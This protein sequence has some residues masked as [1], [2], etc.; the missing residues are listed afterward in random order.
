MNK[1]TLSLQ[2][3][4]DAG[5]RRTLFEE[6]S[7]TLSG[8]IAR[9]ACDDGPGSIARLMER[10]FQTGLAMRGATDLKEPKDDAWRPLRETDLPSSLRKQLYKFR[11]LLG[12][13]LDGLRLRDPT[14]RGMLLVMPPRRPGYP[15]ENRRDEWFSPIL[16]WSVPYSLNA[17]NQMVGFGLF[18]RPQ[19]LRGG[20][21]MTTMTEWGFEFLTIGETRHLNDR[22]PGS[23]LT[24]GAFKSLMESVTASDL[25]QSTVREL[26]YVQEEEIKGLAPTSSRRL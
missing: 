14:A 1:D 11:T 26:G 3:L 23:S 5:L 25:F 17:I 2:D 9:G 24:Y 4:T 13:G 7:K 16:K 19:E 15:N 22:T 6:M 10:A 21:M 20:W 18:E 12:F 8:K